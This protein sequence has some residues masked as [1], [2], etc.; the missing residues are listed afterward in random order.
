MGI[1]EYFLNKSNSYRFYKEQYEKHV[2]PNKN[3]NNPVSND[4][5]KELQQLREEMELQKKYMDSTNDLFNVLFLDYKHECVGILKN[6]QALCTELLEFVN[7][8]CKAN[9]LNWWL[10]YGTLLGGIR[11]NYFI[12][13]DDDTDIGMMREDYI[14]FDKIIHEEVKKHKIDDIIKLQYKQ[15]KIK[16]EIIGSFLLIF[17]R[18][19]LPNGEYPILAGIDVFPYDYVRHAPDLDDDEYQRHY[20]LTK[21]ELFQNILDG[22]DPDERLKIVYDKLD[23]TFDRQ[24]YILPGVEGACGPYNLY[25]L[26]LLEDEKLFPLKQTKFGD[27][28]F[29]VPNNYDHHLKTIYGDYMVVPKTVHAHSRVNK[30]RYNSNNDEIFERSLQRLKEVNEKY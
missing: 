30:L 20:F 4:I 3:S 25:D 12:P 5:K 29:P 24:K 21:K 7:N 16:G 10:D 13:W 9:D 22:M 1:K 23:L 11:H 26:M 14:K 18:D 17:L 6:L 19:Y 28:V 8:I 2:L 15:R 27:K